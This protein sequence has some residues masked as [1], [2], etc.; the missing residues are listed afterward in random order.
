MID[1]NLAA[2]VAETLQELTD[3]PLLQPDW[4]ITLIDQNNRDISATLSERLIN[5]DLVDHNGVDSDSLTLELDDS[6][7]Q[8]ALPP[9]G[10]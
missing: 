7:G 5:L 10:A 2:S 3:S 1:D 8:L 6:D 9:T 4:R